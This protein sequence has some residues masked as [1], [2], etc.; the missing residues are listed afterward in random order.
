MRR[1]YVTNFQK[2]LLITLG[3]TALCLVAYWQVRT[4]KFINYD[5]QLYVTQNSKTQAGITWQTIKDAFTD[6]RTFN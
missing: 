5:D 1:D 2:K 3:L 6:I 4:L